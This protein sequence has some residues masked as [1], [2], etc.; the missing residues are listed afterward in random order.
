MKL[1]VGQFWRLNN[2]SSTYFV[3]AIDR[4]VNTWE[5]SEYG[6]KHIAARLERIG[7]HDADYIQDWKEHIDV[8]EEHYYQITDKDEIGLLLLQ[9]A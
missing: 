7:P 9:R 5:A 2:D 1:E 8:L 6:K 3:Y 4:W